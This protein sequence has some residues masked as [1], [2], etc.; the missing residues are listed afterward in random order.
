MRGQKLLIMY[1]CNMRPSRHAEIRH[2]IH[3]ASID[4]GPQY[5]EY[6]LQELGV[7]RHAEDTHVHLIDMLRLF[8]AHEYSAL[9]NYRLIV[10]V[11]YR[12]CDLRGRDPLTFQT[13]FEATAEVNTLYIMYNRIPIKITLLIGEAI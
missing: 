12:R 4:G 10:P 6:L 1:F 2:K 3:S 13:A 11:R 9:W 8:T 7:T 5:L